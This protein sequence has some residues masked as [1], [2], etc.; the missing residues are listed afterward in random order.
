M[1]TLHETRVEAFLAGAADETYDAMLCDPPY[2]L[3]FMGRRWDY[4]LPSV[5][6]WRECLRVLKPG[7]YALVACG[8]RTQHRMVVALE[9]AG[10]EVV[11]VIVWMYSQ[12][13]PK[14]HNIGNAIAEKGC[15]CGR[16]VPYDHRESGPAEAEHGMHPMRDANVSA[17]INARQTGGGVLF[18][19]LSEQGAP[20]K[21]PTT[22]SGAQTGAQPSLEGRHHVQTEQGQLHWPE[23]RAVP[24]GAEG[25]EPGGR[26][27]DGASAGAG[28]TPRAV[29]GED[30]GRSPQGPQHQ[31]Q[32]VEESG[33]VA[34]QWSAQSGRGG[35]VC[36][37]CG[38]PTDLGARWNGHGTALK[39]AVEF[40]TLVRKPTRL[41]FAQ[42]AL[43]H[44]CGALNIDGSRVPFRGE[45]DRAQT[46]AKNKHGQYGSGPRENHV[47]G[48]MRN[49]RTDYDADA[50]YPANLILDEDAA[51]LLDRQSGH[52][53][54]R[55]T[56]TPSAATA[57]EAWGATFQTNRGA[58][59]YSDE[60]GASRFFYCAKADVA[61]REA[62]LK[63][64]D[65]RPHALGHQAQAE[66]ARG[67]TEHGAQH[68]MG[69]NRVKMRRNTHP[70]V[71]P[72]DL[73]RYLAG[74]L[75]PPP[76][77]ER[78]L[79]VPYAGVASEMIGAGLAGWDAV[80]GAE[81]E[82]EHVAIGRARLAHWLGAGSQAALFGT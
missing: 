35:Q 72:L 11:D 40:Y 46:Q 25:H 56:D 49:D 14:N 78:R 7:A 18:E 62:G 57:S 48:D 29:I 17:S 75:L 70:T 8:T 28:A 2:G 59:G 51:A 76:G 10:F 80:D 32:R 81:A 15:Q 43:T 39:P 20:P 24:R 13:F 65:A 58:R 74:L 52:S 31:K 64:F 41:T 82:A 54:T 71:K 36:P 38:K 63:R 21:G 69:L 47:Y 79:W 50:R 19:G 67:H 16:P 3:R 66:V 12:G 61:E 1:F 53:V 68:S 33:A 22:S 45:A 73:C 26:L 23:V 6:V 4:S 42:N 44:G 9:D 77:A 27:R 34:D 5:D 30:G 60:G 55:R 37:R